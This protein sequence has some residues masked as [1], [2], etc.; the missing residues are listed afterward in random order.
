MDANGTESQFSTEYTLSTGLYVLNLTPDTTRPV[1]TQPDDYGIRLM[2]NRPNPFDE[3]TMI[4]VASGTDAFADR[5][6]LQ[7]T[8]I[9]GRLVTRIPVHLHRGINEVVFN[10]GF[11]VGGIYI[12]SL[13]IDGLPV[14]STKMIFRKE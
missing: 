14:Q 12:C 11:G 2:P 6:V 10:H 9:D 4:A 8:G 7:I 3:S 13:L 1:P 5:T